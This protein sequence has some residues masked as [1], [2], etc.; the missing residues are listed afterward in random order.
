MKTL[1]Q[2]VCIGAFFFFLFVLT[3]PPHN[4]EARDLEFRE[5]AIGMNKYDFADLGMCQNAKEKGP[6]ESTFQNCDAK[7][8]ALTLPAQ[9]TFERGRLKSFSLLVTKDEIQSVFSALRHE[10]GPPSLGPLKDKSKIEAVWSN[11][12]GEI[13]LALETAI[14]IGSVSLK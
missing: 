9:A 3:R 12:K 14:G 4:V 7:Y 6:Y 10:L 5:L 13:T 1:I 2:Y 11:A 8:A